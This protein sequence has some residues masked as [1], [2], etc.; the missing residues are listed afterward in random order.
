[1]SP[2]VSWLC[3]KP[4]FQNSEKKNTEE[5]AKNTPPQVNRLCNGCIRYRFTAL[6][7]FHLRWPVRPVACRS[8]AGR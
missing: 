5:L 2:P 1:M 3:W 6:E 7:A 8:P 4:L